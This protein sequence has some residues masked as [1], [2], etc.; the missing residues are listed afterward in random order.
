MSGG[1]IRLEVNQVAL[2]QARGRDPAEE[3]SEAVFDIAPAPLRVEKHALDGDDFEQLRGR[4]GRPNPDR[5]ERGIG[6]RARPR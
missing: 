1:R 6:G 3:W 2:D 4:F 5:V